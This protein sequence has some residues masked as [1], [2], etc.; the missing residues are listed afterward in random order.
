MVLHA[1]VCCLL[2]SQLCKLNSKFLE[3]KPSNLLVKDLRKNINANL[4]LSR[5]S[6]E[7]NL[8]HNLV[9]KGA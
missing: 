2:F 9:S 4:V 7:F 5:V 3:V 8:R 1:K 6:E